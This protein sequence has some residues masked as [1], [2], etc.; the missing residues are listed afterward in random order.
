MCVE[1]KAGLGKT[2]VLREFARQARATGFT[3]LAAEA[4]ASEA[5][6]A[7]G[8]ATQLFDG[9][10]GGSP[11]PPLDGLACCGELGACPHR[12]AL[13]EQRVLRGLH[14]AVRR[15]GER[16]PV[17]IAVDNAEHLDPETARWLTYLRRRL[18]GTRVALVLTGMGLPKAGELVEDSQWITLSCL[19]GAASADLVRASFP[20]ADNDFVASCHRLTAGNP[21][22]LRELLRALPSPTLPAELPAAVR[23]EALAM[24][25]RAGEKALTSACAVAVL[26]TPGLALAADFGDKDALTAL[27]ELGLCTVGDSVGFTYPLVR[28][29]VASGVTAVERSLI[30]ARAAAF[31]YEAHAP[32]PDIAEQLVET[33][34]T[35]EDWVPGVLFRAAAACPPADA[36]RYLRRLLTEPLPADVRGE[37]LTALGEVLAHIDPPAALACLREAA[38]HALAPATQGRLTLALAHEL[39]ARGMHDD[40]LQALESAS[41]ADENDLDLFAAGLEMEKYG[42]FDGTRLDATCSARGKRFAN[43]LEA[44]RA[45]IEGKPRD[46]VLARVDSVRLPELI[47]GA[48]ADVLDRRA[49]HYTVDALVAAEEFGLAE[50]CCTDALAH[51]TPA[52]GSLILG[53]QSRTRARRGALREADS[54]GRR[55]LQ[56]LPAA[57]D[58]RVLAL[59]V[60]ALVEVW[61]AAGETGAASALLR[62][63]NLDG[64]LPDSLHYQGVLHVRGRLHAALGRHEEALRDQFACGR[65]SG[66]MFPW[67]SHAVAALAALGRKSEA[68]ALAGE[69]LHRAHSRS[70]AMAF[71]VAL[72]TA[73]RVIGGPD[74]TELLADAAEVLQESP[75][76]LELAVTL[77]DWGVSLV[78]IGR[79]AEARGVLRR[80]HELAKLCGAIP[81][82][83]Q[84]ARALRTTGGR[85]SRSG[86]NPNGLTHLELLV[87]RR[88]TDGLTNRSIAEELF[89]TSR[90][91]EQH[92][93]RA[94]RK[95]GIPGRR[96]L[97]AALA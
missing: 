43:A 24:I 10:Q 34:P 54:L 75:A 1:G 53:L 11:E 59:A 71:G 74:G 62:S 78:D 15:L 3:V 82:M 52:L 46:E 22:L 36:V 63:R 85:A 94:Y 40:A 30:R 96:H 95:L 57:A 2:T 56:E 8:V 7:Y 51:V 80:A 87:A 49:L 60:S 12:P 93:T 18:A 68:F 16:T 21:T 79:P 33:T 4:A 92:L 48:G 39:A 29:A 27:V 41:S 86:A 38:G 35:G 64:K 97:K 9:Q 81:L 90:A 26:G 58:Q 66:S 6:F 77:L 14:Q 28:A 50:R 73:G 69:E 31:L 42:S 67:R 55:A 76:K 23:A 47:Q 70:A 91:V 19:D 20:A 72:R 61:L 65:R 84:A 17:L 83:G 5:G 88:A 37:A 44:F 45:A 32:S 13:P 25:G 89:V